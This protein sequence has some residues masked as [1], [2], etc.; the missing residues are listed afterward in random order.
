MQWTNITRFQKTSHVPLVVDPGTRD[1]TTPLIRTFSLPNDIGGESKS[2]RGNIRAQGSAE[3]LRK[4]G[5][6]EPVSYEECVPFLGAITAAH[7]AG[8][9]AHCGAGSAVVRLDLRR[10]V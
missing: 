8:V 5:G 6:Y 2:I 3:P 9:T 1:E 7:S 10:W 4:F